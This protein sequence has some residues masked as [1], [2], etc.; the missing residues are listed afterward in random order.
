MSDLNQ[1]TGGTVRFLERKKTGDY[2]HREVSVELNFSVADGK[3]PTNSVN[4]AADM[5]QKKATELLNGTLKRAVGR[6]PK[7][8]ASA[9]VAEA[10]TDPAINDQKEAL[11]TAASVDPFE[12]PATTAAASVEASS[13]PVQDTTTATM[14]TEPAANDDEW[15]AAVPVITPKQCV[16]ACAKRN[17]EISNP[18]EIR[19]L[20][21]S[22]VDA[23]KGA[24]DIPAER[25]RE[26]LDKLAALPKS[27]AAA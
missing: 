12:A 17:A 14:A 22:Y 6:P 9:D 8:P 4:Q 2:E 11:A 21:A 1:I 5:A 27:K 18:S 10:V 23:P 13:A 25:R 7:V 19:K 24:A 15:S 20:I 26:F 3:D 16:D